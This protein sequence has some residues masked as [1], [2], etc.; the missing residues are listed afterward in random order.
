[1][2]NSR[3]WSNFVG[4]LSRKPWRI[5]SHALEI[6][7]LATRRAANRWHLRRAKDVHQGLRQRPSWL[8][9]TRLTASVGNELLRWPAYTTVFLENAPEA[10]P[11]LPAEDAEA[12]LQTQRWPECVIG[13]IGGG[14]PAARAL[15]A[16]VAWMQSPKP[17]FDPAWEPYS[18]SERVANISV[19]L[20]TNPALRDTIEPQLLRNFLFASAQWIDEH[21]E[22]YGEERSNNHFLNNARALV[23]A[24]SVLNAPE[25]LGRGLAIFQRFTPRLFAANGFLRER[26]SHYQLVVAGWLFDALHFARAAGAEIGEI[27]ALERPVA[28]A[29]AALCA[30][31]PDMDVH[32]GDISPDLPPMFSLLRLR[33]L[34]PWVFDGAEA[35]PPGD[36]RVLVRG[37]D[38]LATCVPPGWP[39]PY[40]THGHA[41]LC[42][43]IWRHAGRTV[44]ADPGRASYRDAEQTDACAHNSVL[45]EGMAPL[46]ESVLSAGLWFPQCYAQAHIELK[47][48]VQGF[49]IEHDGFGRLRESCRHRRHI[50]VSEGQLDVS[51]SLSGSGS[52]QV[53]LLWHFAPEFRL[54]TPNSLMTED[55]LLDIEC[56]SEHGTPSHIS[57]RNY[58]FSAAYGE[59]KQA[60]KLSVVF[61]VQL[62]CM[63]H[64]RFRVSTCAA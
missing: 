64:S 57:W 51:D 30:A 31:I 17:T 63:L 41:D 29:C 53:T 50:S 40:T 33:R 16:A 39:L 27:E 6:V 3:E 49:T 8:P 32:I 42:S 47:D 23:I 61:D 9:Q 54:K 13:A 15:A 5:P 59:E 25:V 10:I 62:P 19:L 35:V 20:A 7:G 11:T 38:A 56:V 44:L 26:S 45:L 37:Q 60:S 24:G 48:T 43:F 1:M 18:A 36:W 58:T 46:A 12:Y 14:A 2:L 52:A 55:S 22:Y 21:L 4:T 34:Y 28:N